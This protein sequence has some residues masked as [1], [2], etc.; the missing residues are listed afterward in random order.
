MEAHL[1]LIT[2]A[3]VAL[4]HKTSQYT[5]EIS[6]AQ[7]NSNQ[8]NVREMLILLLQKESC[9]MKKLSFFGDGGYFWFGVLF[10]GFGFSSTVSLHNSR[11]PQTH[12]ITAP[13]S[14]V[15]IIITKHHASY[16]KIS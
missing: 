3:C 5:F 10:K 2:I 7:L 15:L 11:W 8:F 12:N 1:F 16:E 13:S 6:Q 9:F 4:T 14:P